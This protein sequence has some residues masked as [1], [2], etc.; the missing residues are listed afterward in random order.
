MKADRAAKYELRKCNYA[1]SQYN[2]AKSLFKNNN[3]YIL[4]IVCTSDK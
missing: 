2:S 1:Y 4:S 3:E